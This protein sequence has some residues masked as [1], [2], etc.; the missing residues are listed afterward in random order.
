[1]RLLLLFLVLLSFVRAH[2]AESV[3]YTR[4]E[5]IYGRKFGTALTLD[6]FRPA[7]TNTLGVI[8]II[9]GGFFSSHEAINPGMLK[10]F[11]DRGYTV[12]AVVHGSQPRYI[13]PEIVGDIH[14]S[15]RWIRHHAAEYG[16]RL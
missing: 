13:I 4:T 11:L 10:P 2:A 7:S 16:V 12:F 1:M 14:R 3:P 5:V 9:S 15:V 8:S 6:V